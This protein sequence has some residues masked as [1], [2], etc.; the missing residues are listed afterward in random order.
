[1]CVCVCVFAQ[2]EKPTALKV[3]TKL[4]CKAKSPNSKK[5]KVAAESSLSA[6]TVAAE[7]TVAADT[8]AAEAAVVGRRTTRSGRHF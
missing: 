3:Q 5:R 6:D 8:V 4:Q 7:T 2:Q 1:M